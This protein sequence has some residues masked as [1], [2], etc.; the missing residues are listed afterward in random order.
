MGERGKG[1]RAKSREKRSKGS[2]GGKRGNDN[3]VLQIFYVIS[4]VPI[5]R[6]HFGLFTTCRARPLDPPAQL[7]LCAF[8]KVN[9]GTTSYTSSYNRTEHI[10]V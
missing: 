3:P 7:L 4:K 6:F 9:I 10:F 2:V 5:S 8:A 1:E